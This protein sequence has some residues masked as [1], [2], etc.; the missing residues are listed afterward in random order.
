MF[1][2]VSL[3]AIAQAISAANIMIIHQPITQKQ[4]LQI[5][6]AIS[7][8]NINIIHQPITLSCRGAQEGAG[9]DPELDGQ[10][11]MRTEVG[12]QPGETECEAAQ[13]A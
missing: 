1:S 9:E 12:L 4:G 13:D 3:P 6:Q 10:C 8:E 5:A 11:H 2:A 7:A